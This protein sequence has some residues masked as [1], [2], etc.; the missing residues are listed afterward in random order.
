MST[1]TKTPIHITNIRHGRPQ[2]GLK[3]QH[4]TAVQILQKLCHATVSPMTIGS[5]ELTW[6]PHE[7]DSLHETIDIQTAGSI[8][9][10]LQNI[11][12]PLLYAQ[13]PSSLTIIGGTDVLWSPSFDYFCAVIL[14]F[15]RPYAHDIT[16]TCDKRGYYPLGQGTVHL[17]LVPKKD[18]LSRGIHVIEQKPITTVYGKVHASSLLQKN[19]VAERIA[20]SAQKRLSAYHV[21]ISVAYSDTASPGCCITLWTHENFL[22]ADYLGKK[23]LSAETIGHA[24]AEK[25]LHEIASGAPLD[26][27]MTDTVIPLLFLT[28]GSIRAASLTEHATNAVWV[29]EQFLGHTA[30]IIETTISVKRKS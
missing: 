28:G 9:L 21:N 6:E 19:R 11:L 24:C 23:G 30:E 7:I 17:S 1:L 14:P 12:I 2:P 3:A 8:P 26:S 10:L 18:F 20:E 22:G 25:L 29:A 15:F 16:L 27:H 4:L 5:Q 13:Q